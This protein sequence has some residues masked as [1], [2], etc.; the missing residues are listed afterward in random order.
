MNGQAVEVSL[1]RKRDEILDGQWRVEDGELHLDRSAI[2]VDVDL[3]RHGRRH[4]PGGL[5]GLHRQRRRCRTHLHRHG[6]G[7][8]GIQLLQQL[9]RAD[10]NRPVLVREGAS[11]NRRG[12]TGA[13]LRERR[14]R[15]CARAVGGVARAG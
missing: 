10:A 1:A 14:E 9:R 5:I 13:V 8:R 3:G 15:G 11:K 2:G 4:E 12:H 6:T 7:G